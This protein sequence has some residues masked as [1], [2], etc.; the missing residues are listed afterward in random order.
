ML[1]HAL[2]PAALAVVLLVPTLPAQCPL[3]TLA[4]GDG[5]TGDQLG[6]SVAIDGEIAVLG[7]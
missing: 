4:A 1:P 2:L 7:A 6:R 3:A 5:A